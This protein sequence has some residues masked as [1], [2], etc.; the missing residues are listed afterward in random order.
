MAN[1]EASN[2]KFFSYTL[3]MRLKIHD[4]L[5]QHIS[6]ARNLIMYSKLHDKK[7][8]NRYT[9]VERALSVQFALICSRKR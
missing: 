9:R 6:M 5:I 3:S 4:L 2:F 7:R 1:S 8:A